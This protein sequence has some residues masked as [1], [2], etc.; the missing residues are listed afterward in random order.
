VFPPLAARGVGDVGGS[1]SHS[2]LLV[3][4]SLYQVLI[5]R[6]RLIVEI[7]LLGLLAKTR[8]QDSK[9]IGLLSV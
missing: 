8:S 2:I 9:S 4:E 3:F 6:G 5:A 7:A 1:A